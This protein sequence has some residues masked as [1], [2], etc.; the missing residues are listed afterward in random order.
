MTKATLSV[1]GNMRIIYSIDLR[2]NVYII[3]AAIA[4]HTRLRDNWPKSRFDALQTIRR[5]LRW[6]GLG[7]AVKA[8]YSNRDY[9]EEE[10]LEHVYKLFPELVLLKEESND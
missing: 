6:H 9:T 4:C 2:I 1:D 8:D 7:V 5:P 10:L 3:T